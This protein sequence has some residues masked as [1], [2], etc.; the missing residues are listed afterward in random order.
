[1]SSPM[2]PARDA[3]ESIGR[4]ADPA[5]S[6]SAGSVP[7]DRSADDGRYSNDRIDA[8]RPVAPAAADAPDITTTPE[9]R[10]DHREILVR[11]KERFGGMKLGSAFFGWLAATGLTVAT[12]SRRWPPS[13]LVSERSAR[14]CRPARSRRRRSAWSAR[15]CCSSSCSWRTSPGICGR[16]DGPVQRGEAGL[17]G[18]AVGCGHGR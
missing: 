1:M 13:E 15:S 14:I 8:D 3:G 11:Q 9:P 10:P 2:N 4:D 16:S 12:W 6:G 18:V 7:A 5:M 17:G